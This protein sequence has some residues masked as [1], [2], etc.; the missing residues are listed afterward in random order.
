MPV[1]PSTGL[2]QIREITPLI[3]STKRMLAFLLAT[4]FLSYGCIALVS[5]FYPH[6]LSLLGEKQ[7][8]IKHSTNLLA[9]TR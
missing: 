6:T 5:C 2:G 1:T 7:A 4:R 3:N 9:R 8:R